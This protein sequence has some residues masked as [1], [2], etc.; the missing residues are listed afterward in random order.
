MSQPGRPERE[1]R[2]REEQG[3]DQH[4]HQPNDWIARIR[5]ATSKP[6]AVMAKRR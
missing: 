4:L 2:A 5:T 1:E 3:H 6:S